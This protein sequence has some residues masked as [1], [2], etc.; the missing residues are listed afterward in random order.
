L[1]MHDKLVLTE[2]REI[3]SSSEE[4][5][6]YVEVFGGRRISMPRKGLEITNF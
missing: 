4:R 1:K 3:E 5:P 2:D 6:S